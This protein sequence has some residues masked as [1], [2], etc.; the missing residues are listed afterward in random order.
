MIDIG[1]KTLALRVDPKLVMT[2]EG[3]GRAG[4]PAGLSI[5]VVIDG[6]WADPRITPDV[7]GIAAGNS[8]PGGN[9]LSDT[10]GSLIQQ[11]LNAARGRGNQ[12][13]ASPND[14]SAPTP[15]DP[16]RPPNNQLNDI[17]KQLFGR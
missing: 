4:D 5:P 7:A 3:Q 16:S 2:T 17:M 13:N 8:S 9:S 6:P 12:P 1:A 10:I 15:N 14:P 11:G